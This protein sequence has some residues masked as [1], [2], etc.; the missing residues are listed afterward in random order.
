MKKYLAVDFIGVK[1]G[2][3]LLIKRN[4]E[5]FKEMWALP[6]GF[7]EK[8]TVWEAVRREMREEVNAEIE[9]EGVLGLYSDPNRDPRNVASLVFYGKFL[10]D[11]KPDEKEVLECRF[12][13]KEEI[14]RMELAADHKEV[15]KDFFEG[16]R[17]VVR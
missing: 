15:L 3:V 14:E 5:P 2:K 17:F 13:S 16:K 9:I 6:G 10:T 1:D 4:K 8:E 11:P 7:V 12:F